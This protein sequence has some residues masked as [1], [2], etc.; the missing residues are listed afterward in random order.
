MRLVS[1]DAFLLPENIR[2]L[3]ERLGKDGTNVSQI[4]RLQCVF[5]GKHPLVENFTQ[6]QVQL[7]NKQ[8]LCVSQSIY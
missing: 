6:W 1:L 8:L 7:K 5:T 2:Q 4:V 3:H